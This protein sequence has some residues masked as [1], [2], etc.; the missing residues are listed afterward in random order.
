MTVANT[1]SSRVSHAVH[2]Y[3]LLYLPSTLNVI[4]L[5]IE[6]DATDYLMVM[7]EGLG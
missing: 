3:R 2:F 4:G 1:K 7:D 6:Q 5:F